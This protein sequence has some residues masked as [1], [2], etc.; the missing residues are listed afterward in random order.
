MTPIA[1]FYQACPVCG[2]SI[3]MPVQYFG[4]TVICVHC[5]GEFRAEEQS[6]PISITQSAELATAGTAQRGGI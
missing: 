4:R 2:R 3:R 5:G 1:V 6:A